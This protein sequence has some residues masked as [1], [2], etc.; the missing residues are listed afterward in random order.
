MASDPTQPLTTIKGIGPGR[1]E[2]FARLGL[3]SLNDLLEFLPR[4]YLDYSQPK[5]IADIEDGEAAAVRIGFIGPAKLFRSKTKVTVTTVSIGDETGNMTASWFNQPY[6]MKAVPKEPG[7]YIVGTMD[8]R[9]GARFLRASF[10][11]ELPGV[12]PVYPLVKG[13][14][15]ASVRKAVKAALDACLDGVEETLPERII[16][17]YGLIPLREAIAEVHFPKDPET[18]KKARRRLAFEDAAVLTIVLEKLRSVKKSTS[19]I[20]FNTAGILGEF[21]PLLPFEPTDAQYGVMNEIAL[22]MASDQPMSRL[23][24]GDVGSGKT[25]LALYAMYVAAKNGYQSVLM[26]PTEILAEQH[27]KQL[28][29]FFGERAAILTGHMTAKERREALAGIADGSTIAVCGT[30]ALI[31]NGV[32]FSNLGVVITDEQHRFGVRQRAAIGKKGEAPDTLIMSATPIPRTLS[33]ILYGDLDISTVRGMP[34][35]RKPA[36]TKLV[37][38]RKRAD[39][40]RY[41]EKLIADE[42]IQA[43]VVCPMIEENEELEGVRSAESLYEELRG[44]LSLRIGLLHGR[45]KSGE[46]DELMERFRKGELDMLV[47]TTVIEVG[48]DV[49]NACIMVIESAERFGLAQLHQLRGRVGRGDKQSYCFLLTGSGSK[50]ALERL[51]FLTETSDGFRIA[52][53]D[54]ELRG[55]GE[56]IGM[57]QHGISEFGAAALAM[58]IETLRLAKECA[59]SLLS[60]PEDESA[61][62]IEK[63]MRKYARSLENVAIN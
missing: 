12:V 48:V 26:A 3:F 25:V 54:L 28:R 61:K 39:M 49:P 6:I 17:E 21:L 19:G 7:G 24:Q 42:R 43:Y 59:A 30:H 60:G 58:D 46:K 16:T 29:H 40:Y 1:A 23:I 5:K 34:P 53:K 31:E 38:E 41:I 56:L 35:G 57:R 18:L 27:F 47:S 13:L 44:N 8:R 55:P 33:L 52:E 32:E 22:D 63:A 20:S 45:M 50:T 10:M 36:V 15:Q 11:K 62:I 4:S 14:N 2:L 51:R 37:P 9:S